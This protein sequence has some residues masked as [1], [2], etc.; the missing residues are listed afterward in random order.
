MPKRLKKNNVVKDL[1]EDILNQV[2]IS[3]K[4]GVSQAY[5]SQLNKEL[6]TQRYFDL[7]KSLYNLMNTKMKFIKKPTDEDKKNVKEVQ[8][9][10]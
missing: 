6:T 8:S 9:L 10:L 3:V 2:E 5:V 4:H 1:K 7:L